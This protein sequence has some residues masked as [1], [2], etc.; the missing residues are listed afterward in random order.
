[1]IG[2]TEENIK[3]GLCIDEMIPIFVALRLALR[4]YDYKVNLIFKYDPK[5]RNRNQKAM[6]VLQHDGHIYTMNHN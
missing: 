2:K 6:Y 3:Q 5:V 1:M 4:V